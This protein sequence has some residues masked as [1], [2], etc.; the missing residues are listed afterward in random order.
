MDS[1]NNIN[2]N[3]NHV[4]NNHLNHDNSKID[5]KNRIISPHDFD[6]AAHFYSIRDHFNDLTDK[7]NISDETKDSSLKEKKDFALKYTQLE[8]LVRV[9]DRI[10]Y[11]FPEL[12]IE[13]D[14]NDFLNIVNKEKKHYY[15]IGSSCF[16]LNSVIMYM[17]TFIKNKNK[18]FIFA[19]F[20]AFN[21]L[22]FVY[23]I[24]NKSKY[25]FEKMI[26][27]ERYHHIINNESICEFNE[28]KN[29]KI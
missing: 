11:K 20:I 28:Y 7:Q 22:I 16:L 6:K 9:F 4:N 8:G 26:I 17:I 18:F 13:K 14:K 15:L 27:V 5:Q 2:S 1:I 19:P 23:H 24:R 29:D 21:L 12:L 10:V 3:N 25:I